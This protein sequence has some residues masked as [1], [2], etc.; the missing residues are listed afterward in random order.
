[1][2]KLT[3]TMIIIDILVAC[4]FIFTY[5]IPTVRN[6]V[7]M[8]SLNTKTHQYIAYTFY[9][10]E[11]INKVVAA[12]SFIPISDNVKLD[13]IVISN[14]ERDSYDD[15]YDEAILTRDE[16]NEDYKLLNIKVGGYNAYLVAIYDPSKVTL[17]H[18][19]TF[20]TGTGQE[21]IKNMCTRYGGTVCI[22][23]G[24]FVD[25]GLGSDIPMGYLI[26]DSKV[27][28][29]DNTGP[30]NLIGFTKDNKL[31]L[32]NATGEEA[33]NMG[34]RDALEFG[35]FLIVNGKSIEYNSSVGG[36]SRA[37]RVAIGQ[38]KDGTVLFL[39]T[40]GT[41]A[42][43]P[44]MGEVIE[45][46]KKY[47]AYNAANLDGGSSAQLAIN[48][49]LVNNPKNIYGQAIVGGRSVVSGFGLIP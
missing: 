38:R 34:M 17:I 31:L 19:K 20:G 27:I 39:V 25:N 15:E 26:K 21:R 22:N 49:N 3:I 16:G 28:W 33:I 47:K 5:A 40:E 41:H 11:T 30:A 9:S 24:M 7:I 6:V 2:K 36:Y 46:L 10:E 44:N 45:T 42:F 4:C 32:V 43:G 37:A 35:P 14:A 23:G 12:D 29:Q 48:G 1:M 18:S 8:T 13:D